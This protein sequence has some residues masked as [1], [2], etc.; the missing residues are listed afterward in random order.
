MFINWHELTTVE[1]IRIAARLKQRTP[2]EFFRF[3]I[4]SINLK[5]SHIL[6]VSG[7]QHPDPQY[8]ISC[9]LKNQDKK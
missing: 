7:I 4:S 5:E 8:T 2:T 1:I 6:T 9:S 3:I